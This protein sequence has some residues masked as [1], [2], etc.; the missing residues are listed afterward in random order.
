MFL[1]SPSQT[2]RST[3]MREHDHAQHEHSSNFFSQREKSFWSTAE[4]ECMLCGRQG[5]PLP[6][7]EAGGSRSRG[8]PHTLTYQKTIY[9]V[10]AFPHGGVNLSRLYPGDIISSYIQY[11]VILQY[12]MYKHIISGYTLMLGAPSSGYNLI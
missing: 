5:V 12:G 6:S 3:G 7:G 1:A 11:I 2:V 4:M 8:S 9:R 10:H